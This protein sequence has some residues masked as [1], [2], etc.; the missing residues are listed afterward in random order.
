MCRLIAMHA[1]RPLPAAGPLADD[2][3][4]LVVQSCRD[5]RGE[6][7]GDGWGIGFYTAGKPEMVHSITPAYEDST[8]VPT[9]RSVRARTVLGHVRQASVGSLTLANTHPFASGPWMFAHNGTVTGFDALERQLADET[10]PELLARRRGSTDSELVFYWLLTRLL[11]PGNYDR[12]LGS[13]LD[14]VTGELGRALKELD[15]RSRAADPQGTP[16]FNFVLT[17]G[18]VLL[19]TRWDHQLQWQTIDRPDSGRAVLIASEPTAPGA[20]Q[21]LPEHSILSVGS[22]L[23]AHVYPA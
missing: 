3:H 14:A 4:A 16:R 17:D 21:E 7:H 9:A 23:S 22:N 8:F 12:V 2:P 5:S 6:R 10:A 19:A 11:A 18:Q 13:P 15:G 1:D 20:W